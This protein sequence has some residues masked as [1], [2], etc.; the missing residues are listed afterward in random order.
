MKMKYRIEVDRED[1]G[2]YPV[3]H[4]GEYEDIPSALRAW[5]N[6]EYPAIWDQ[7]AAGTKIHICRLHHEGLPME[8]WAYIEATFE[9]FLTALNKK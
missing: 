6:P 3:E 8:H 9:E 7:P 1:N 5:M 4:E 2:D